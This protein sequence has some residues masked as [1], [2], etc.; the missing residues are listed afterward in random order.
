M[1]LTIGDLGEWGNRFKA[2]IDASILQRGSLVNPRSFSQELKWDSVMN[3]NYTHVLLIHDLL[4]TVK[5]MLSLVVEN[6]D[7]KHHTSWFQK[8]EKGLLP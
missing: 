1:K 7:M 4:K 6:I 3:K 8:C 2:R 5:P